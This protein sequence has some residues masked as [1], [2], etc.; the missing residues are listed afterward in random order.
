VTTP[1]NRDGDFIVK[2]EAGV[3][4]AVGNVGD[5]WVT[6]TY[7]NGETTDTTAMLVPEWDL[8]VATLPQFRHLT[9]SAAP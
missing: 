6:L 7:T 3:Q 4:V 9:I 1:T 5:P 2:D 8:V